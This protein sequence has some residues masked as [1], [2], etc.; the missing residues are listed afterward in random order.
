MLKSLIRQA[1]TALGTLFGMRFNHSAIEDRTMFELEA[2][3]GPGFDISFPLYEYY[4]YYCQPLLRPSCSQKPEPGFFSK[5]KMNKWIHKMRL[6]PDDSCGSSLEARAFLDL[7]SN[8]DETL[9]AMTALVAGLNACLTPKDAI[10][11][12]STALSVRY[13]ERCLLLA[14]GNYSRD[15]NPF[16]S[17]S[18]MNQ[19]DS[20][21]RIQVR[22]FFEKGYQQTRLQRP[23]FGIHCTIGKRLV[24]DYILMSQLAYNCDLQE[25]SSE[26]QPFWPLTER[27][28]AD[29]TL[30]VVQWTSQSTPWTIKVVNEGEPPI[31]HRID[32]DS[33]LLFFESASPVVRFLSAI[34][35]VGFRL[36]SSAEVGNLLPVDWYPSRE[37]EDIDLGTLGHSQQRADYEEQKA[38]ARAGAGQSEDKGKKAVDPER[39][40]DTAGG[41]DGRLS[42]PEPQSW[43]ATWR[44]SLSQILEMYDNPA[45][46]YE[47]QISD[48]QPC[49][50]PPRLRRV[51]GL[52]SV[53]RRLAEMSARFEAMM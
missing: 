19:L 41:A 1:G 29:L 12:L 37:L 7:A 30:A 9:W 16:H 3:H 26:R 17:P 47:P 23:R 8:R 20:V 14:C 50:I 5:V 35:A 11:V 43:D 31:M 45:P 27:D 33:N 18:R 36:S 38:K 46:L 34:H 13:D 39:R 49:T 48:G 53:D 25:E 10:L 6:T 51:D 44:A 15:R 32:L 28:K 52:R 22:R 42:D 4:A 2:N 21:I 40:P 24:E